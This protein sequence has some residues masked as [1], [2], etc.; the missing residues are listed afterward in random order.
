MGRASREQAGRNRERVV[1]VA[2]RLFR[3]HGVENVSIADVMKEAG[4]TPGGFYK[5]FESRVALV[6]E[7][8]ELAFRQSSD[9][10]K[11][12]GSSV[13]N[14][15]P[16]GLVALM[17]HYFKRRPLEQNCP[18]LAFSSLAGNT[19]VDARTKSLYCN[20]VE[21]LYRQFREEALEK[22]SEAQAQGKLS[23]DAVELLFA[24]MVGAGLLSKAM[25]DNSFTRSLQAAVQAA[26]LAAWE[27]N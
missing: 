21:E 14:G 3:A 22:P 5:Q 8:F 6:N 16:R 25:G 2:C 26:V 27:R 24:A 9:A 10:W 12:V 4:L 17:K 23:D 13:P 20:G 18:M 11:E 19:A 15:V 1:H 7:A